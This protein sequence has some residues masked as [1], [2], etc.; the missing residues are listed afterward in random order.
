MLYSRD[1]YQHD[2]YYV[3]IL[4]NS[5]VSV[6]YDYGTLIG[7]HMWT[8]EQHHY[9]EWTWRSKFQFP[10]ENPSG[11]VT[12]PFYMCIIK[13]RSRVGEWG[14]RDGVWGVGAPFPQ[15]GRVWG[16]GCAP[17]QKFFE[18]SFRNGAFLCIL[19]M[20]GACPRPLDPPL[21]IMIN[22][23]EIRE[24]NQTIHLRHPVH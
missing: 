16:G 10:T 9:L 21:C 24:V 18:F 8:I 12:L 2:N 22:L 3:S 4:S 13:G 7:S 17:T 1:C 23:I 20:T 15:R 19:L 11:E 14:G 6:S 5:S